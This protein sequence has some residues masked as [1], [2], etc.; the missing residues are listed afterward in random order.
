MDITTH[1]TGDRT[2]LTI[3]GRLDA[4]SADQVSRSLSELIR[5]GARRVLLDLVGVDFMS[6]AGLRVLLQYYKQ[7]KGLQGSLLVSDVSPPVKMVIALA[8]F[9]ELLGLKEAPASAAPASGPATEPGRVRRLEQAGAT[10]EVFERAPM[11]MLMCEVIGNPAGDG[12]GKSQTLQFPDGTFGVGVGAFGQDDQECRHRFGD[13]LAAA[14]AVAYCPTDGA[15]VPDYQ[16]QSG[17]FL[18]DAQVLHCLKCEGEFSHLLRFE[19]TSGAVPLNEL[20]DACLKIVR[21]ELA[22]IVMVAEAASL[23]G[24]RLTRSPAAAGGSREQLREPRTVSP[25]AGE[26]CELTLLVGVAARAD[27][28]ALDSLLRQ[29]GTRAVPTG[30]FAAAV[31][32]ARSLPSGELDRQATVAALFGA[33]RLRDL[34]QLPPAD[35]SGAGQSRL[36]RGACWIGPIDRVSAPRASA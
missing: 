16:I 22:G 24:S 6:S 34:L 14:G 29:I 9:E 33:G 20:V 10:F 27:R 36:F 32:S 8:G 1:Q 12:A 30:H 18:P 21:T 26:P 2:T 3:S 15:R 4:Q 5:G 7:L 17:A 28:P 35:P 11:K 23:A 13:L 19:A 25:A 31:F